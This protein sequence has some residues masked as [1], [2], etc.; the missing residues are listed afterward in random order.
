[1]TFFSPRRRW[2]AIL[3]RVVKARSALLSDFEVLQLLRETEEAQRELTLGSTDWILDHLPKT[4]FEGHDATAFRLLRS[5]IRQTWHVDEPR[6]ILH[7]NED[8]VPQGK[9]TY[10][11]P[12]LVAPSTM[13]GNTDTHWYSVRI[14]EIRPSSHGSRLRGTFSGS[15][16]RRCT[17]TSLALGRSSASVRMQRACNA[18]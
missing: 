10:K 14:S 7:E 2:L 17:R 18:G 5:V 12:L 9:Q 13:V 1:M 11:D 8:A 15:V 3:M 4:P 16:P 6:Q